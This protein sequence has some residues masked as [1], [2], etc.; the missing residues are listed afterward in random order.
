MSI[1]PY[2]LE[3]VKNNTYPLSGLQS[4][5]ARSAVL[6]NSTSSQMRKV[7]RSIRSTSCCQPGPT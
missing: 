7:R 1:G 3:G 2:E 5:S 6:G 4:S